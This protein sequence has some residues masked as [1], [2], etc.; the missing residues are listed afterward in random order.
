MN[1]EARSYRSSRNV[2][3][4]LHRRALARRAGAAALGGALMVLG[5][6][7]GALAKLIAL[8]GGALLSR[9]LAGADDFARLTAARSDGRRRADT[10]LDD[11][12]EASF[13]A[14]DAVAGARRGPG[15]PVDG[16]M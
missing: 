4:T 15:G 16:L 5:R 8:A 13:P 14:S 2:W 3:R 7:R 10:D 1:A 12:L 11:A 6:R 9:A